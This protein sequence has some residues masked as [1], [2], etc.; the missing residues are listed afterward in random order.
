MASL[1]KVMLIGNLGQEPEIRYTQGGNSVCN[2]RIATTERWKDRDTGDMKERTEWHRIIVWG[3]Q[4]E[5]C[6]EYLAK[7]R[8]VHVEGKLQTRK[9]EDKDGNERWTTEVVADRVTF[10]GG[11]AEPERTGG[12][13]GNAPVSHS[14]LCGPLFFFNI[15]AICPD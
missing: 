2:F 12:V 6:G 13:S 10:L 5:M 7:G 15:R 1:N 8:A 11:S 9:W 3:K 4:A 14:I